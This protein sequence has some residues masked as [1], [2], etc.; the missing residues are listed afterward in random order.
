MSG[1]RLQFV[2]FIF[3]SISHCPSTPPFTCRG[4]KRGLI[5]NYV[6]CFIEKVHDQGAMQN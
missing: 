1:L 2:S 6:E 5:V 4:K 3:Q